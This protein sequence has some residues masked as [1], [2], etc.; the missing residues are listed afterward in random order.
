MQGLLL[1]ST[2]PAPDLS[3]EEN[4]SNFNDPAA[5]LEY[6]EYVNSH[7]GQGIDANVDGLSRYE[8]NRSNVASLDER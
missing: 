5:L 4:P 3:N 8:R 6:I 7:Q 2:S 1:R